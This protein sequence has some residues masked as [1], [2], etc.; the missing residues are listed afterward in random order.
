MARQKGNRKMEIQK[1]VRK[2]H[3]SDTQE[4]KELGAKCI[5]E[6][7]KAKKDLGQQ[8]R[9]RDLESV[10]FFLANIDALKVASP[11]KDQIFSAFLPPFSREVQIAE[12]IF[13]KSSNIQQRALCPIITE[14]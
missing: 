13:H 3:P 5:N 9:W 6:A 2:V 10:S 4:L 7:I 1:E 14:N 8:F 12:E 11:L